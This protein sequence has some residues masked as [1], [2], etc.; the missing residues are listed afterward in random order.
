MAVVCLGTCT[1]H[2]KELAKTHL[3]LLLQVNPCS[4]TH[5]LFPLQ[6]LILYNNGFFSMVQT[7]KIVI[8]HL[9]SECIN[10]KELRFFG[11]FFFL[12]I[13]QLDEVKIR[14]SALRAII[15]LLLL[16]GF[17][18]LSETASTQTAQPTQSPDKQQ[19]DAATAEDKGDA[20]EDIAQSILVMF[21]ELL[22]SEVSVHDYLAVRMCGE[23]LKDPTAP[24]VRLYAK[25]LSNLE[26]SREETT[27]ED[28]TTLLQQLVQV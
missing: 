12:Q 1:L 3:V 23:M 27:R 20:P 8:S 18:L 17:Q 4:S 11:V 2:S 16:F 6:L 9:R 13:A 7:W 28:L 10:E 25:T 21:S 15:D 19:A 26:I 5:L 22:D 24:E 14:I